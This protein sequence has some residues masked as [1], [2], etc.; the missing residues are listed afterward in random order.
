MNPIAPPFFH[1]QFQHDGASSLLK[2]KRFVYLAFVFQRFCKYLKFCS[3][4]FLILVAESRKCLDDVPI[5]FVRDSRIGCDYRLLGFR[6]KF[7]SLCVIN[8]CH[9]LKL[10]SSSKTV[11]TTSDFLHVFQ[12]L[13]DATR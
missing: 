3:Y 12:H 1:A 11:I 2:L 7:A 13:A 8:K 9:V 5:E 4:L 6:Q 10:I